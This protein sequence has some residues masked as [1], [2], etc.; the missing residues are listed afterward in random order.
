MTEQIGREEKKK[1]KPFPALRENLE[2]KRQKI[3]FGVYINYYCMYV[4]ENAS[5]AALGSVL[6]V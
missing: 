2:H 4:V 6:S 3:P 1:K 5:A